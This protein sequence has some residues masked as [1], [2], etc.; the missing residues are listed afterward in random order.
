MLTFRKP[1]F[2]TNGV[3]DVPAGCLASGPI[4]ARRT[5]STVCRDSLRFAPRALCQSCY[6]SHCLGSSCCTCLCLLL[7]FAQKQTNSNLRLTCPAPA[8]NT[9]CSPSAV[10]YLL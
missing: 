5:L 6:W 10:S 2:W 9:S 8:R 7:S 4:S 1:T 3:C